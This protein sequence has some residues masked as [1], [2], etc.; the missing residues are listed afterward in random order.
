VSGLAASS[1]LAAPDAPCSSKHFPT[2]YPRHILR[3]AA[4]PVLCSRARSIS[5]FARCGD[6]VA[7]RLKPHCAWN[8]R[9]GRAVS[10]KTTAPFARNPARRG[11]SPH[12]LMAVMLRFRQAKRSGGFTEHLARRLWHDRQTAYAKT[13]ARLIHGPMDTAEAI[14]AE[15]EERPVLQRFT[16]GLGRNEP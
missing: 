14:L 2:H 15:G 5:E 4:I 1:I 11:R 13:A 16:K 3:Q 10:R 6:K 7:V 8:E 9:G 12:P